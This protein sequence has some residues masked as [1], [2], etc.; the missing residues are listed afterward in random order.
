MDMLPE[1]HRPLGFGMVGPAGRQEQIAASAEECAALAR[2]FRILGIS[3]FTASLALRRE[4]DGAIRAEGHIEAEVTQE[5]VISLEPV[6]QRVSAPVHL[7]FLPPGVPPAEDPEGPDE[8]ETDG[9][10]MDLGEAVAEQLALALDPFPRRPDAVLPPD[11][12]APEETPADTASSP[13]A[14]LARLRRD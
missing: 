11:V 6:E 9:E 10:V 5:C 1:L 12:L 14:L 7:R 13:F 8:I 3:A 2:R 4:E